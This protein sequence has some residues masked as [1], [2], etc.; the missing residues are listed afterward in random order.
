MGATELDRASQHR[1]HAEQRGAQRYTL[2]LR[3]AKLLCESG[4][5]VGVV[6]DVSATGAKIRLFHEAPPDTHL[7]LELANGGRYAM[8]RMWLADDHAGFRFS[9]AIDVSEFMEE[10]SLYA[11]RPLRLRLNGAAR[12]KSRGAEGP[13]TL[14][15]LSQHGACIEMDRTLAVCEPLRLEVAEL[16]VRIG[17]VRWRRARAYGLVFQQA[18]RLDELARH[19]LA[20]Q[21][22]TAA[23]DM[24][25]ATNSGIAAR[26]A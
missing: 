10:C 11:R 17:H 1:L 19:A 5:Y 26:C 21:P 24:P 6:R 22:F 14:V 12:V 13:A 18:Y 25:V 20:L 4:E 3:A 23:P 2:M 8:E 15:N 7:F 9:S 16:P